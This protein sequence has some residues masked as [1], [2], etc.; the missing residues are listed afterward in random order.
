MLQGEH[1]YDSS[2][3]W[4]TVPMITLITVL[5]ALVANWIVSLAAGI[6]LLCARERPAAS[7]QAALAVRRRKRRCADRALSPP[8]RVWRS[9]M[10][11]GRSNRI[12]AMVL[13]CLA[14]LAIPAKAQAERQ[15]PGSL[16]LASNS[17]GMV[18]IAWQHPDLVPQPDLPMDE[19]P[20]GYK[21][22]MATDAG[23]RLVQPVDRSISMHTQPGLSAA[24]TYQVKVCALFEDAAEDDYCTAEQAIT[25]LRTGVGEMVPSTPFKVTSID[26]GT[27]WI[28][29]SWVG[30]HERY[31]IAFSA[32]GQ[33]ATERSAGLSDARQFTL[34]DLRPGTTYDITL[35]ACSLQ[36]LKRQCLHE[37]KAR[38]TTGAPRLRPLPGTEPIAVR[39]AWEPL[40]DIDRVSFTVDGAPAQEATGPAAGTLGEISLPVT[41]ANRA[42]TVGMCWQQGAFSGCGE[43]QA[44][45]LPTLPSAPTG[46][47]VIMRGGG[48]ISTEI[49]Q[50]LR[51]QAIA[52]FDAGG[53]AGE[54]LVLEREYAGRRGGLSQHVMPRTWRE[55]AQ[56]PWKAGRSALVVTP[57]GTTLGSGTPTGRIRACAVVGSLGAAG[58]ACGEPVQ[59]P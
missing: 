15:A 11:V 21:I 52:Q 47:L 25:T 5:V 22:L 59:A 35:K 26:A 10:N 45:P 40:P 36:F 48:G 8:Q 57:P 1:G 23:W 13:A 56:A 51:R 20:A 41:P 4:N 55:I 32:E 18:I 49:G 29:F 58:R 34:T 24:T 19:R 6:S 31:I 14:C 17:S 43:A 12:P 46:L 50:V 42:Y 38:P 44:R 53:V 27:T 3:V 7:R 2:I 30:S 33:A 54:T 28:R 39:L 37:H 9:R 16:E